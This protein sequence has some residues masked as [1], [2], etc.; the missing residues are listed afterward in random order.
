[1][2][3]TFTPAGTSYTI[4]LDASFDLYQAG[5]PNDDA[6][7]DAFIDAFHDAADE[8]ADE[9]GITISVISGTYNGPAMQNQSTNGDEGELWQEIHNNV[10]L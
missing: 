6:A 10:R 5:K 3:T 4:V 7:Q 2:K 8:L 1:M 9:I